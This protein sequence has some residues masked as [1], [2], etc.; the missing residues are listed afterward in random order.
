MG[1]GRCGFR[2][3][4]RLGAIKIEVVFSFVFET[5]FKA[6]FVAPNRFLAPIWVHFRVILRSIS[7]HF[8]NISLF[9]K[10]AFRLDETIVFEELGGL[11]SVLFR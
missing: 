7:G 9:W 3:H 8:L 4:G 2:A 10:H 6:L 11:I 5:L 1:S